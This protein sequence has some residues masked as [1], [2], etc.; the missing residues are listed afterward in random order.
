M[1][2]PFPVQL[3]SK[4]ATSSS[5]GPSMNFPLAGEA[6]DLISKLDKRSES[7]DESIKRSTSKMNAFFD[8][9]AGMLKYTNYLVVFFVV[10]LLAVLGNLWTSYQS[11]ELLSKIVESSSGISSMKS[12]LL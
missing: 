7:M 2:S 5:A 4:A 1:N 6:E 10:L 9:T 11:M 12:S 3:F 8:K